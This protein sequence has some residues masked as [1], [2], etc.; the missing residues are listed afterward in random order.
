MAERVRFKTL[1]LAA[2]QSSSATLYVGDHKHIILRV[3]DFSI[4]D[5]AGSAL[6]IALHAA[7]NS[8]TTEVPVTAL[9]VHHWD[10]VCQENRPSE[11]YITSAGNYEFPYPGGT[12]YI[13]F[14]FSTA[15]TT[16]GEVTYMYP[17]LYH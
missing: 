15:A 17:S 12:P 2:S 4:F 7:H 13:K 5:G 3:P 10:Y 11:I 8:S 16:A 1:K 6:T 9:A 14:I